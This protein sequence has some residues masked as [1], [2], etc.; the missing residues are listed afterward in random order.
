MNKAIELV[1]ALV[2][3]GSPVALVTIAL[4]FRRE[5][6]S[7]LVALPSMIGRVK[8]ADVLGIKLELQELKENREAAEQEVERGDLKVSPPPAGD[9]P[10][11]PTEGPEQVDNADSNPVSA[12]RAEAVASRRSALMLTA[13][14][15][16]KEV[17][18]LLAVAG[19]L[20]EYRSPVQAIRLL[21]Q[22]QKTPGR[23]AASL[24]N[25]FSVRNQ[26]AHDPNYPELTEETLNAG[27]LLLQLLRSIPRAHH[28]V[29][30]ANFPLYS[31]PEATMRR[32][33]VSGVMLRGFDEAGRGGMAQ[34]FPTTK[35]MRVGSSVSWEWNMASIWNKSWYKDPKTGEICHAFDSS[36]EFVG[37]DLTEL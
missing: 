34:V 9:L 14:Y 8:S 15:I 36:A 33:G 11:G 18:A 19:L 23:L 26:V 2:P 24:E 20:K 6:V 30:A 13:A 37:R 31:D 1:K 4:L 3:L 27:I 16:E 21:E 35:P 7:L 17:K 5:I 29:I 22:R 12:I 32:E 25:F 10:S 28:K